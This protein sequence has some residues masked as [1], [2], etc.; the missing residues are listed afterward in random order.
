MLQDGRK[1]AYKSILS[2]D[3]DVIFAKDFHQ[4]FETWIRRIDCWKALQLGATQLPKLRSVVSNGEQGWFRP[5]LTDGSYATAVHSSAYNDLLREIYK[6][7]APFDSGPLRAIYQKYPNQCYV[8]WPHLIIANVAD[9]DI[10]G[11][12]DMEKIAHKLEW[13]LEQ[14]DWNAPLDL[15]SVVSW[16][17]DCN[18]ISNKRLL[19]VFNGFL[20]QGYSKMELIVVND[21]NSFLK[22]FPS[23]RNIPIRIVNNAKS[24]GERIS[25]ELGI[26]LS[27]G[28]YVIFQK[29]DHNTKTINHEI[30]LK[31][32]QKLQQNVCNHHQHQ[33]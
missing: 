30:E 28:K 3:D 8:A 27:K 29:V 20:D 24:L 23:K 22:E 32:I 11:Q 15:I 21:G 33:H 16:V 31:I 17:S 7:N 1:N 10:R 2:L 26:R 5:G 19:D 13:K 6:M 14:Y 9:S 12:K 4:K 18:G 25:R